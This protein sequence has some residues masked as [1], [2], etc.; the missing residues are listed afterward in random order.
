MSVTLAASNSDA[1]SGIASVQF[2]VD[3]TN[4][5]SSGTT[6]PYSITW[7]STSVTNASH[8]IYA[9]AR[10]V[11]G[12]YATSSITV[13]V[14]N[15]NPSY[16][17]GGNVSGLSGTLVL[18]NNSGDNL[19]ISANGSF[20]FATGLH[21][22]DTYSVTVLTQPSGQTCSV[23]S[24]SGTVS[25]NVTSIA[26]T[27]TTN[28]VITP[29]SGG[30][31]SYSSGGG[32]AYVPP[33]LATTTVATT[34]CKT[35]MYP[36]ITKNLSQGNVGNDVVLLQKV[37]VL[38]KFLSVGSTS[39]I[40][41]ASTTV[42]ASNFQKKYGIVTSGTP[43]TTGFGN[44]GP[45]TRATINQFISQGKYPSLGQCVT[46]VP[47]EVTSSTNVTGSIFTR[48]LQVGS[49]GADV[50]ALQVFLN[51]HGFVVASSGGGSP[52]NETTYF[53]S[54]TKAAL[55]KF[56][57]YYANDILTPNGLTSGTGYFGP[58]TMRKVNA[59]VK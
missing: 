41:S 55:I 58:A 36:I 5:G 22:S 51:A 37:L 54:A 42:A 26:I 23:S 33:I 49:T 48:T 32:S 40:Y 25:G 29:P 45:K 11:T 28:S 52:G 30:G 56:Q 10:D 18:Q 35:L 38:E 13:T 50:K 44:V 16:N 39:S 12:N 20:T 53:G 7:D 19:S 57:E 24:G 31:G 59:M 4:T 3:G 15:T 9:V 21:S 17:I 14:D 8:T 46:N 34:T 1:G 2:K 43:A 6:N 27:C 47:L